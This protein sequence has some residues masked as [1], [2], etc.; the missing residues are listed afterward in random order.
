MMLMVMTYLSYIAG[1]DHPDTLDTM[2]NL[3]VSYRCQSKIADAEALLVECLKKREIVLG[4]YSEN[5]YI[6]A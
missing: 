1:L 3:A 6:S 2:N 4:T 5:I